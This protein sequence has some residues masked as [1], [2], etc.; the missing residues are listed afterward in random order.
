MVYIQLPIQD[1]MCNF[2]YKDRI[3]QH[4]I[5]IMCP[6]L[7]RVWF[8]A[9]EDG[10]LLGC[11]KEQRD[12]RIQPRKEISFSGLVDMGFCKRPCTPA[13]LAGHAHLMF[14]GDGPVSS[15]T[16]LVATRTGLTTRLRWCCF[17]LFSVGNPMTWHLKPQG[18]RYK[19]WQAVPNTPR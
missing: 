7:F 14:F 9:K 11:V 19:D 4:H 6:L 3:Y 12:R 18:F 13:D 8:E 1:I 15:E 16:G 17:F 2:A 5:N 10:S